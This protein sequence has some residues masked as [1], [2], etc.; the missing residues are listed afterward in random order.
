MMRTAMFAFGLVVDLDVFI[1][2]LVQLKCSRV[3]KYPTC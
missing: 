1:I 3:K 2:S